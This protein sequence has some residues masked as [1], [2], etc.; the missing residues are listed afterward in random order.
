M[1]K[2]FELLIKS[3]SSGEFSGWA[4]TY[5]P[6]LV[7]DQIMPGAFDETLGRWRGKGM[8]P[9]LLWHHHMDEPVGAITDLTATDKGL[10]LRGKLASLGRGPQARE[11]MTMGT[12]RGLSI[13]FQAK[14]E[15]MDAASGLNRIYTV[16]LYEV[17]L[18]SVPANTS[19]MVTSLA[20]GLTSERIAEQRLRDLGVS[21]REALAF[22][23]ALKGL[24]VAPRESA[25]ATADVLAL[26]A[27]PV[28]L[29]R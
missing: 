2:S 18:C 4:S 25:A 27:Q 12:L 5:E 7:N 22:L 21:R 8:W 28:R 19:A 29:R 13:G 10:H 15:E 24:E 11:L 9:A 14:R 23:A 20:K 6:D 3:A 26:I 1:E 17:S 16:D